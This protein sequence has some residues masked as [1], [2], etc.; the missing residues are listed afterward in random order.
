MKN[1]RLVISVQLLISARAAPV[2]NR[3]E[4]SKTVTRSTNR[5]RPPM[6]GLRQRSR[7]AILVAP[8]RIYIRAAS[9]L[10]LCSVRNIPSVRWSVAF[11]GPRPSGRHAYDRLERGA[12]ALRTTQLAV[13][14]HRVQHRQHFERQ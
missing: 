6:V 1:G 8:A 14:P 4:T 2:N 12:G 7:E 5:M 3:V 13:A 10:R 9:P 11:L